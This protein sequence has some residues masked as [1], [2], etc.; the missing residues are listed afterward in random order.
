MSIAEIFHA[1]QQTEAGTAF[2]E[3]AVVYPIILSTHLSCIAIFG[4]MI[5]VTNLRLLGWFMVDV[6]FSRL[7]LALRPWKRLGF[8]IMV[9]CGL[10]LAGSEADKYYPNPIFWTKLTLILMVLV[11]YIIF[12]GIVYRNPKALD[13]GIPKMARIA[14]AS[15]LILW[16]SIVT[17]G[18]WIAYWEPPDTL[19]NPVAAA[20]LQNQP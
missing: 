6:P 10:C 13:A 8:C 7:Y 11:H 17:A 1:I 15:S 18:R 20:T 5:L 19:Q 3:S 16:L 12:R 4:G 14:A 9:G 2:R